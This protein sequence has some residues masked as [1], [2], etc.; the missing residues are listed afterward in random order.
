MSRS[1]VFLMTTVSFAGI[2][3]GLMAQ[4]SSALPG[5]LKKRPAAIFAPALKY[6]PG[7]PTG[8]G[9]LVLYLDK[10]TGSVALVEVA[11]STGHNILDDSAVDAFKKRRFAPDNYTKVKIP[12]TFT[13]RG[14]RY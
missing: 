13:Q 10:A 9:L 1:K 12:I 11:K 6:G 3:H 4:E 7:W 14:S 2:A 8:R 5:N